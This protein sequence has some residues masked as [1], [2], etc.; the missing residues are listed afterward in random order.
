MD[1]GLING[2]GLSCLDYS[3][4]LIARK[5]CSYLFN[6]A[7]SFDQMLRELEIRRKE[8]KLTKGDYQKKFL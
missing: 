1:H 3:R 6:L 4:T 2:G 5:L 8:T 7:G